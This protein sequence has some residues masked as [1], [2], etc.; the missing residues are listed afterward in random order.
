M[1][2]FNISAQELA[3]RGGQRSVNNGAEGLYDQVT[4]VYGNCTIFTSCFNPAALLDVAANVTVAS[5]ANGDVVL[6]GG[7]GTDF[8]TKVQ[9]PIMLLSPGIEQAFIGIECNLPG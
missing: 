5:G 4:I 3:R 6:T 1:Y 7:A 2:E 8:G 9:A